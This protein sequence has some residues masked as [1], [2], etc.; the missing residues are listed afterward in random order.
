M[1]YMKLK[2][3]VYKPETVHH[4][5]DNTEFTRYLYEVKTLF[6]W[7]LKNEILYSPKSSYLRINLH[8][9]AYK[10]NILDNFH[11]LHFF[12]F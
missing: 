1:S 2:I 7:G 12:D 3:V 6:L 11:F 5:E 10:E 4:E 8:E 9:C